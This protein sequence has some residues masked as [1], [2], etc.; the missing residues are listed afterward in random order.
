M[1][2]LALKSCTKQAERPL[3]MS[4]PLGCSEERLRDSGWK[5]RVNDDCMAIRRVI[6]S[7]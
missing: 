1:V 5:E 7:L 2:S 6:G 4:A 3:Y